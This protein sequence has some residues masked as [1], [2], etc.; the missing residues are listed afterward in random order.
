MYKRSRHGFAL[1]TVVIVSLVM[2]TVLAAAMQFIAASQAALERQYHLQLAREA[3]E[4]GL[5]YASQCMDQNDGAISWSDAKPLRP[6]TDCNGSVISGADS[7]VF[8]SGLVQTTFSIKLPAASAD[9]KT[10][11]LSSTG[12]IQILRK[13]DLDHI[14]KGQIDHRLIEQNVSHL[15]KSD[16]PHDVSGFFA[17]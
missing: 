17:L 1:P 6:N 5:E 15:T 8:K 14:L 16:W 2:I 3:G 10:H 12:T 13:S 11:T 9:G 4:S 7:N